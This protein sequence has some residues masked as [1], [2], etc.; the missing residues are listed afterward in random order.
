MPRNNVSKTS[1]SIK[2]LLEPPVNRFPET[3][4]FRWNIFDFGRLSTET[5]SNLTSLGSGPLISRKAAEFGLIT[6][7]ELAIAVVDRDRQLH[8]IP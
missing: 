8:L 6:G 7:N 1:V 4:V 3:G 2:N 5:G